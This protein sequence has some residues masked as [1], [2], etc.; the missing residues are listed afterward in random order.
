M[1]PRQ[2]K[3]VMIAALV[4]IVPPARAQN[5]APNPP[6]PARQSLDDAWW[7]GPML[8]PNASTLPRGHFL[9]EPYFYDV[10]GGD[11]FDSDG[12]RR[13]GPQS[14]GFG[15]LTYILYGLTDKFT[16]GAIP[17]AGYNEVSDGPNSSSVGLGDVTLQAQY[18]L[19]KYREGSWL[20]TISFAL[21][22]TLP[23]GK[24]DQLGSRLSDAL[25]SGAFTT[26]LA[27]YT[28]TYFWLPN[29]RIL[30]TRF[31]VTQSFSKNVSVEGASVFGTDAGFHGHAGPG[32]ESFVDAA[33]EYSLTR[34]WVL[35]LDATYRYAGNTRVKGVNTMD[36]SGGI[37]QISS[38][39]S[40]AFGLAPAI[41]YNW[42]QNI[43]VLLGVRVFPAGRNTA[44][45]ITPAIAINYVH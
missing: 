32:S 13:S 6:P 20:P 44:S 39:S 40:A 5:P 3:W 30:R 19:R 8:A 21:Q 36:P 27:L 11:H 24:Y 1:E 17:T 38:G 31:N 14:N 23:T 12:V 35:A 25:G 34:N 33:S 18:R 2:A 15:S 10:I 9:I 26:A 4:L 29:R 16:I 43:G 22:E 42:K 37:L 28:Q 41:E 7:T 45:T